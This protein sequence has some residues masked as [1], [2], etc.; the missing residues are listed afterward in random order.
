M[1]VSETNHICE[2]SQ[3]RF[4]LGLLFCDN[5]QASISCLTVHTLPDLICNT[6]INTIINYTEH[7][8]SNVQQV[9]L[10]AHM[11]GLSSLSS[12]GRYEAVVRSCTCLQCMRTPTDPS[13]HIKHCRTELS[14]TESDFFLYVNH[15]FLLLIT[16]VSSYTHTAVS[17]ET[18]AFK[19]ELY[20]IN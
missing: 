8:S 7:V 18:T 11:I 19:Y 9:F 20:P 15:H 10:Q 12:R 5:A 4:S 1:L 16:G 3:D 2:G 13:P 14:E 6:E 17:V